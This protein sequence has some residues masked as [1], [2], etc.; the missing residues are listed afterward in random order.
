MK[1][2]VTDNLNHAQHSRSEGQVAAEVVLR[3]ML[4]LASELETLHRSG[5]VRRDISMQT[6]AVDWEIPRVGLSADVNLESLSFGGL[7]A[8][9][10]RCP[11]ELRRSH[12]C[13]V[14]ADIDSA[15]RVLAS[16]GI[17]S[18]PERIDL[19][20]FGTLLCRLITGR[21]IQ[22][23]LSSP[24]VLFRVPAGARRIIDGCIGYD[25]LLCVES[26]SQLVS[27][28]N[29][30]LGAAPA[31][32]TFARAWD[33][34]PEAQVLANV[35]T[36]DT[37]SDL[38]AETRTHLRRPPFERLGHFEIQEEIGHGGMGTVYRAYDRS[39][40]RVVAVKVLSQ[41]L[42]SDQTFVQRF[43]AEAAAAAR[44]T[45]PNVVPI[46]FIGE[47]AGSHFYAMRL[48]NGESL[49]DRLHREPSIS[50]SEV[51][52]ILQQV[53]LGLA[54]AH[55]LGLVHRD[56]KPGNI[57]IDRENG[58]AT[59]TDFGL[60]RS[61][62]KPH[63]QS[64]HHLV[65]GTAEY[66][67]P[68]QA[69]GEPVDPRSDLYSVGV[70]LY[71]LLSGTMPFDADT[72]SSHLIH[73]VCTEPRPLR[74]LIPD[75]DPQLEAVVMRLLRKRPDERYPSVEELL[76]DLDVAL[77]SVFARSPDASRPMTNVRAARSSRIRRM[78]S[79]AQRLADQTAEATRPADSSTVSRAAPAATPMAT[80]V[81]TPL[82]RRAA[83]LVIAG[84]LVVLLA[85]ATSRFQQPAGATTLQVH[86]DAVSAL[87]FSPD[88]NWLL[89]GGGAS[90][91]LKAAGDTSLRLWNAHT[92][93]LVNQSERLPVRP[94]QLVFLGDS[95]R[96]VVLAS[97]REDTGTLSVWDSSR[98]T[99]GPT[100]FSE[101]F[102]MHFDMA[103]LA[104]T[105]RNHSVLVAGRNGLTRV[106]VQGI[107][108]R[109]SA[110]KSI[111]GLAPIRALA[112]C[113]T[114]SGPQTF[115]AVDD[116]EASLV[117]AFDL[118]SGRELARLP[119]RF[120]MITALAVS[121]DGRRL[122]TRATESLV[123]PNADPPNQAIM[124]TESKTAFDFVR[125]WDWPN[126]NEGFRF[127]PYA[128]GLR[129]LAVSPD[130]RRA[131]TIAEPSIGPRSELPQ[132]AVWLDLT[133][134][135]EICRVRT[136][137]NCLTAV[138]LSST[139]TRAALADT[140]GQ[141][142]FCDLPK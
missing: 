70:L 69:Q 11:P 130:G 46:Y 126:P 8:D 85:I 24:G 109:T 100:D 38:R 113:Q 117:V 18:G 29:E 49:A 84:M 39:L 124:P 57:L 75:V 63:D 87:A 64:E 66:M 115:V 103:L 99:L 102:A 116:A 111:F 91:S 19:Y 106:A 20:Q 112:V 101:P 83:A 120:G 21:S 10:E 50:A 26:A 25:E 41:R 2:L 56:I 32:A 44:L 81:T 47:D 51:L 34:S 74:D 132:D 97:A 5:R 28:L 125:V 14:P 73:H 67:S 135:Q 94:R 133:T 48:I 12:P 31:V 127:G 58:L 62:S 72:P 71:Q 114:A 92:G 89:S 136:S 59:L 9:P 121:N 53:L 98:G 42:A 65:M 37:Q 30:A 4:G 129:A 23:Y 15:R 61:I 3:G 79:N 142:V 17:L 134:G 108:A 60:A 27:L 22:A 93:Q 35:A 139:G 13:E 107:V 45:H 104:T 88:G 105:D 95:R 90:S 78:D 76:I 119:Y 80:K 138:A 54:A 123:R 128:P 52:V 118:A 96:A 141:V 43:Q 137:S 16:Q 77:D 33:E 122:V 82:K 86:H 68:E 6:V 40:D 7:L 55:R 1:Q 110:V 131:L 140:E 36:A